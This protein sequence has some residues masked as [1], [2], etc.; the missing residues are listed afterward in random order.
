MKKK[1]SRMLALLLAFVMVATMIPSKTYVSAAKKKKVKS[2]KINK[3]EYVLKK[4]GKVT[5]KA[6]IS[7]AKLRKKV[8]VQWKSSNKKVATVSNK[9]VVKAVANKGKAIITAKAG[10]KK[11][12]C[13]I[14]VG[15]VVSDKNNNNT[16]PATNPPANPGGTGNTPQATLAPSATPDPLTIT[17]EKKS[18]EMILGEEPLELDINASKEGCTYEW[19]VEDEAI[20]SVKDGIITA[21]NA[22]KTKVTVKATLGKETSS[23]DIEVT[24]KCPELTGVDF[25]EKDIVLTVNQTK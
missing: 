17:T 18:I 1:I 16:A 4:G 14:T 15:T 11:A 2:I 12:T 25:L 3:K 5:L 6:T 20:V 22:G 19:T 21:C 23:L 13:K 10:G 8:K 24:V 9:G 7:P